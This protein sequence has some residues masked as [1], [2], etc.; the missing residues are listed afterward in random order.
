MT[1][2][3][4]NDTNNGTS[5]GNGKSAG[6]TRRSAIP[7]KPVVKDYAWGIRGMDSRVARYALESGTLKEVDPDTPYAELWIGTHHKGPAL[8]ES[9]ESLK[10]AVGAELPFLFKVLSAGKALSIQAHPDKDKAQKLHSE[11]P[12]AYGDANHKPEMAI[13]L[14]PFEA[15]CGFRRLEEIAVLL[16]KHPEFAACISEEAKL[17]VFLSSNEESQK[18]ALQKLF[19]SFMSCPREISERNLQLLLVRLQAEQSQFHPHPHDEPAWERKCGRAILRLAQQFP[20]DAG[21]MAPLFLNYLL[22]APGESFFMAANEPHAYVAGE[23]IECMACSDNVVRAGLTPKFKD[24]PN[25][26]DML[27]YTMGGPSIDAGAPSNGDSRI[28]RYTPPVSEFE[29]MMLTCNPGEELVFENP[30]VPA[31]LIILEGSGKLDGELVR[32]G[33]AHYYPANA[34]PMVFSLSDTRRGPMKVAVA[35]KNCHIDRPTAFNKEGSSTAGSR[36]LSVPSSPLPYLGLA[37]TFSPQV[38]A[39]LQPPVLSQPKEADKLEA[40]D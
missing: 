39:S 6:P 11:N 12:N 1:E 36:G 23:I 22:M 3:R 40:A 28:L 38:A 21:A 30:G 9:G 15:M 18:E 16:K 10:D 31:V 35:H 20:G 17:A 19:S 37:P 8:L 13:A 4:S 26:V 2:G 14:T 34:P 7:L 27:T 5:N 25:L 33:R 29:V 32:P 24:V